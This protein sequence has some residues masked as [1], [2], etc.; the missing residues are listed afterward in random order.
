MR[1]GRDLFRL[2]GRVG[3]RDYLLVGTVGLLLKYGLDSVIALAVG[4]VWSPASYF[5]LDHLE[6]AAA[7]F[8][9]GAGSRLWLTLLAASLP[10]LWV[11]LAMT[12]R[13]LRD[14]R[15]PGWLLA[16]F[17]VPIVNLVFFLV[18]A[19]LPSRASE[20]REPSE[21]LARREGAAVS[22]AI[23]VLVTAALGLGVVAFSTWTLR[24]LRPG[25]LRRSAVLAGLRRDLDPRTPTT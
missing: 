6:G 20:P 16:F 14:A 2:D 4:Y 13:R 10:F 9:S 22:A 15:A 19:A 5:L 7:S 21:A 8:S 11:G 1:I 18:L 24:A 12:V 23:A 3:R 25:A 17:F